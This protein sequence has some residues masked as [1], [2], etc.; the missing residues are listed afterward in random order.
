MAVAEGRDPAV[1]DGHATI[2]TDLRTVHTVRGLGSDSYTY[3]GQPCPGWSL[4]FVEDRSMEGSLDKQTCILVGDFE[5]QV[6]EP[7]NYMDIGAQMVVL[8]PLLA[9]RNHKGMLSQSV[10]VHKEMHI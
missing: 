10:Q 6:P 2:H 4:G 8:S 1:V 9:A 3:L 7:D 5:G